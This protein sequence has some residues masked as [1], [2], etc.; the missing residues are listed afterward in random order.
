[1][2]PHILAL[3]AEKMNPDEE[4]LTEKTKSEVKKQYV[5]AKDRIS[6]SASG[7][8]QDWKPEKLYYSIGE[9]ARLFK[10]NVSHIRYWTNEFGLKV[11]TNKKG[12]RMYTPD[13][14][15]ELG[16]IFFLV[17]EKGFTIA[18]AKSTLKKKQG[19]PVSKIVF[20]HSLEN[21]KAKLATLREILN[22]A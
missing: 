17:K 5:S 18:G 11:R 7:L 21:L 10:I 6:A 2:H 19:K 15:F 8:L 20:K 4:A 22:S 12:D 3:L 14:V 13:Q 16:A 9:V 1:M